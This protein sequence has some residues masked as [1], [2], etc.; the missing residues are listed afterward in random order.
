MVLRADPAKNRCD[1]TTEEWESVWFLI[2]NG[3]FHWI[4]NGLQWIDAGDYDGDGAS[5]LLLQSS[6]YNR[7]GY[8][9]IH[10]ADLVKV[11]FSWSYH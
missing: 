11:E 3:V 8:L 6:G 2:R 4:G 10:I 9:L 5:E 7:D 1:V